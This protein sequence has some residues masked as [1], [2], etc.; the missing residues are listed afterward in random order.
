MYMHA[1]SFAVS[2]IVT[3]KGDAR[4][5]EI[6][7]IWVSSLYTCTYTCMYS[8]HVRVQV[9]QGKCQHSG[10]SAIFKKKKLNLLNGIQLH[11]LHQHVHVQC[12]NTD[13][14]YMYMYMYK[15][16]IHV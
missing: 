2:S 5:D 4:P 7:M 12:C 1:L 16:V 11:D 15:H 14:T 13:H 9:R 10:W 8:V 3:V 6:D